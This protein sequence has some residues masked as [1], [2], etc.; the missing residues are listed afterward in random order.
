[1]NNRQT[2]VVMTGTAHRMITDFGAIHPSSIPHLVAYFIETGDLKEVVVDSDF[3]H[4]KVEIN[5]RKIYLYYSEKKK[6]VA[7][8]DDG[9]G[10]E[11]GFDFAEIPAGS[12]LHADKPTE[13]KEV[14][15][16]DYMTQVLAEPFFIS[17]KED[18]SGEKPKIV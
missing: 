8:F 10:E 17:K 9:I 15:Y 4:Q 7:A 5:G 16:P 1:M 12:S 6:I 2:I 13:I 11:Y 14:Q 18:G 3:P